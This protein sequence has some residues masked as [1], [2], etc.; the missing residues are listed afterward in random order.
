MSTPE[1]MLDFIHTQLAAGRTIYIQ[2]ALRTIKVTP[3]TARSWAASGRD[4]FRLDAEGRLRMAFGRR[5]DI[6]D[7]CRVTAA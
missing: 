3:S 6:I 4:L 1:K 2:T 5:Y 7:L